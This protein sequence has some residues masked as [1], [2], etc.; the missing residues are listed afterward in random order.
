MEQAKR[1]PEENEG[2]DFQR[3][4]NAMRNDL[5]EAESIGAFI[6]EINQGSDTDA[7]KTKALG[8]LAPDSRQRASEVMDFASQLI[9]LYQDK[10]RG[11][12]SPGDDTCP[13]QK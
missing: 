7:S 1:T 8:S 11:Q 12:A 4:R 10:K 6:D 13:G 9:S 2:S 5:A 3:L